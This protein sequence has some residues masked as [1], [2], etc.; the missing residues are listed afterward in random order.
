MNVREIFRF[1]VFFLVTASALFLPAGTL[2][3]QNAWLF[4]AVISVAVGSVTFGIFRN[5]PELLRER[6]TESTPKPCAID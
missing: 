1:L 3:W 6:T 2:A 4:M 5:S